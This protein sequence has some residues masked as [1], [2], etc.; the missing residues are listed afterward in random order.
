[1]M[2]SGGSSGGL[3]QRLRLYCLHRMAPSKLLA[4]DSLAYWRANILATILMTAAGLCVLALAA[5]LFV[6][7]RLD[8]WH[9]LFFDLC[10]Y[11]MSIV[12]LLVRGPSYEFRAGLAA[13]T[14]YL[15][16]LAVIVFMG[17]LSGGPIWLFASAIFAGVFLGATAGLAAALWNTITLTT[18]CWLFWTGQMG[19]GMPFFL[20]FEAMAAAVISF[21]VLN[22]LAAVSISVLVKGLSIG[23][24]KEKA[25][26]SSLA[27][28]RQQLVAAKQQLEEEIE[29]R[30]AAEAAVRQ[31]ERQ[32]RLLADNVSDII[33]MMDLETLRMTYVSPSVEKIRGYTPEEAMAQ[34][35]SQNLT[36]D[37]YKRIRKKFGEML[38]RKEEINR[39]HTFTVEVEQFRKGGGTIHSEVT[40]SFICND[41]QRPVSVMGVTRDITERKRAE[42]ERG[43]LESQLRQAKKMEAIGTL[44]GGIAHDFNNILSSIIGF[45]ELCLDD[46]PEGT[47]LRDNLNEIFTGGKR[48]KELV[49]QILTFA[50]QAD[51]QVSP[52]QIGPI[53]KETLKF[54]RSSIPSTIQIQS[55]VQSDGLIMGNATQLHQVVMNLC[56]NAADAMEEGG[57]LNVSLCDVYFEDLL[58]LPARN[59]VPGH[60]L[61]L[62]VRDTG[63]G[64]APHILPS[65]FDPY[66]TT[67]AV[68]K[69]TGMGLAV[70]HGIVES[71]GG[72]IVVESAPEKGTTFTLFLPATARQGASPQKDMGKLPDGRERILFVDDEASITVMGRQLLERLGY[73]VE[74]R[75]NSLEALALFRQR[76]LDFDLVITDM[77]M[78]HLPGDKLV[79]ELLSLRPHLPI[80][81][82]TGYSNK[83]SEEMASTLGVKGF[84]YKP[85]VRA[86]FARLVRK[87]LDEARN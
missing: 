37:S 12:L 78:P 9:L 21:T 41:E 2:V 86:D 25:L 51:D 1:M 28:E 77:T 42:D 38:R 27:R 66:F 31:S 52:I 36:P 20:T 67:K 65:I 19:R 83:V 81:L 48:A 39:Q 13:L 54:L 57:L 5:A 43:K 10:A 14:I 72:K 4:E 17:P 16:G 7:I 44:A 64:I 71:Y 15:I 50:R 40:F 69:G 62:S 87:V 3:F 6:A 47:I 59:M 24:Q 56:A 70:V 30:K 82:C 26:S 74:T 18:L 23:H 53:V 35:L 55:D 32:Y 8:R 22:L 33:W 61:K 76:P 85:I 73:A 68:G 49:K 34:P 75:T 29:E 63:A 58:Q 80:I 84:A 11:A 79:R 46:A 45:T 60:Y